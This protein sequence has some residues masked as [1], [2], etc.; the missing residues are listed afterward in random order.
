MIKYNGGDPKEL[1]NRSTPN[2][3]FIAVKASFS[4]RYQTTHVINTTIS[5]LLRTQRERERETN[6]RR[7]SNVS[8]LITDKK[9]NTQR[10]RETNTRMV[11]NISSL[12]TD[13][14]TNTQRNYE[15]D[16]C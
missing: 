12:I 10:E 9:T 11:R 3:L 4:Y 15:S 7:V 13:K 16:R 6:T 14:E 5:P 2:E 8:S 1:F